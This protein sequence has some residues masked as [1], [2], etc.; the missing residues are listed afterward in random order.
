MPP[1]I[2]V[3]LVWHERSDASPAHAWLRSVI[4]ALGREL[5]ASCKKVA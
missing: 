2:A 4:I 5:A 3:Q 1:S